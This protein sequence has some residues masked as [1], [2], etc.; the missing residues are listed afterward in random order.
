[1]PGSIEVISGYSFTNHKRQITKQNTY[2][3]YNFGRNDFSE[4]ERKTDL[5]DSVQYLLKYIEKSG[6][7]LVYSKGLCQY[8]I[9][10]IREED[11]ICRVGVD[12]RKLLLF[13]DFLCIDEGE[14]IGRVSKETIRLMRMRN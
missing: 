1:M 3:A 8:F 12:D 4:I 11:V 2:F 13:D 10:D 5:H 7:K 14:I 9:S 6:E